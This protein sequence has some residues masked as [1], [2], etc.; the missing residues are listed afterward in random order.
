MG[1]RGPA[2]TPT[3]ILRLHGSRLVE[4]RTG[5]PQPPAGSPPCP[6][7]MNATA[8]LIWDQVI[9]NLASM[10]VLKKTDGNAI[11]RY[12]M[13]FVEW[14]DC[15]HFIQEK[16]YS[17]EIVT[18]KGG[19]YDQQYPEVNIRNRLNTDLLRLEQQFGLTPAA[20]ASIQVEPSREKKQVRTRSRA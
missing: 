6:E 17:R 13:L 20:R 12:C 3:E 1:K 7:W 10:G 2:P 18:E 8:R 19:V 9:E 16:G 14:C 15:S 5:E 11:A 4:Q